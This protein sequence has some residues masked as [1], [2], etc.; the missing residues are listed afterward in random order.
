MR[1]IKAINERT[2]PETPSPVV[3]VPI[4][5]LETLATRAG[6]YAAESQAKNTR[7]AY[8]RALRGFALWSA[9]RG[10]PGEDDGLPP[11]PTPPELVAAFLV[12]RADRE[13]AVAS[14]AL[15]LSA[16]S[17]AHKLAGLLS[18]VSDPALQRVWAGIR[19]SR[20]KPPRQAYP[21]S[22]RE[23]RTMIL[24][25]PW[26]LKAVRDRCAM[27]LG[28]AAAARPEE[29]VLIEV[30]HLKPLVDG[31]LLLTI[32]H[33]K[34]DQESQGQTVVI[35]RGSDR[36]TCPVAALEDWL[37]VSELAGGPVLRGV[38]YGQLTANRL[39]PGDI[40]KML[41]AA[42]R[43]A[44]FPKRVVEKTSAYSLRRGLATTARQQGRSLDS[45]QR[46][47]RHRNVA[48]TLRYVATEELMKSECAAEGIGL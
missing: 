30:E 15:F 11:L 7:R 24:A 33:S 28:F 39:W 25:Q 37:A 3:V 26:G 47:C 1:P 44:G 27:L 5:G 4:A 42:A 35:P 41:K 29:L 6:Q 31:R 9:E 12:D 10:M 16:L 2:P 46:Q 32:P 8:E 13:R 23:L 17:D 34:T 18:P 43:R 40:S 36:V 48:T 22:V 38:Q 19:R 21:L 14:M 20:G 45:I